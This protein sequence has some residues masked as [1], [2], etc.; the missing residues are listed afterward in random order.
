MVEGPEAATGV[1]EDAVEDDAHAA[2]VRRIEQFAKR[3]V[4]AKHRIYVEV[5]VRVIAMV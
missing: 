2:R 1:I 4:A 5:V 3:L